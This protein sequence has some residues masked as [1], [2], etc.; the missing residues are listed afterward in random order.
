[1]KSKSVKVDFLARV[2][3]EGGISVKVR[4]DRVVDVQ[5]RIFEPPRFFEA[6]LR[7][8]HFLEV[9]DITARIC[10]I[11]PVA[12]QMSAC[13]AIEAA[14][15]VRVNSGIRDLRRLLFAGEWI[16]SHGLH[17]YML[18]APDFLGYEDGLQLAK[19]HP[20][21]VKR[22]LKLKK[23]GN[24]L[25]TIV[26]GRE[27][28]PVNVRVGGFYRLPDLRTLKAFTDQLKWARDAAVETIRWTATLP[29]PD[30]EMDFAFVSLRHPDE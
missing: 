20:D 21:A 25:M 18:H 4:D 5:M 12:Y 11:C 22:G 26:G 3:G 24:E 9:P 28:H 10:G 17:I 7:E 30:F 8:R 19:D 2:E 16:E 1:M 27:I 15:G 29:F 14:F 13:Q 23:I 6:F